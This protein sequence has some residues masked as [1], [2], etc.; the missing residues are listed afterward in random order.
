MADETEKPDAGKEEGGSQEGGESGEGEDGAAP[1]APAGKKKL[2]LIISAVVAVIGIAVAV[3]VV[4]FMGGES[5][6]DDAHAEPALP[7]VVIYDVPEFNLSLLADDPTA[8]H[9]IKIKLSLQLSK[10]GDNEVVNKLL[11]R[12]QDDWGGLLRQMRVGDVQG[13]ANLHRLKEN[14]LRRARQSLEP[15]DVQAVY[16]RELLVQ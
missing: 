14:L 13:S 12:L 10:P 1:A 8:R 16:I 5:K 11:P 9:F 15:V 7:N 4:F 2:L 6:H 3:G